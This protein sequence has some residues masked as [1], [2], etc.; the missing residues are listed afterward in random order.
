MAEQEMSD[1]RSLGWTLLLI[2]AAGFLVAGCEGFTWQGGDISGN[3][4]DLPWYVEIP[5]YVFSPFLLKGAWVAIEIAVVSM[6][7]GVVLGLGLALMRLSSFWPVSALAW[8]YIWFVRGTPQLLQLVFIFNALPQWGIKLD[9][10]SAAVVGFALNEAAFSAELIRGGIVSVS[11]NQSI[12]AASLGMGWLTT[13]R[14]I[15]MPQAMRTILPGLANNTISMIKLTSIASVIFVNDLT[16]R[17]QQI[18]AQNFKF[19]TVFAAAGIIYL[20]ITSAI[21][22]LQMWLERRFDWE[23]EKSGGASLMDRM[24]GVGLRAGPAAEAPVDATL[25]VLRAPAATGRSA[26]SGE[27]RCGACSGGMPLCTGRDD[28]SGPLPLNNSPCPPMGVCRGCATTIPAMRAG[29]TALSA[30]ALCS[31]EQVLLEADFRSK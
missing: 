17:S 21:S 3:A 18:V 2:V 30:P 5:R 4:P 11:R 6:V 20:A 12:A 9:I 10:F 7:L 23:R 24:L 26:M 8:V 1:R 29:N 16:F 19:F 25:P 31:S 13:L 22:L 27:R 14:R 15:V 28:Q